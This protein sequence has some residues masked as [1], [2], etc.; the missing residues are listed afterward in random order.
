MIYKNNHPQNYEWYSF[1]YYFI[2]NFDDNRYEL[3]IL[4]WFRDNYVSEED[5]KHYYKI[6]PIIVEAIEEEEYKD[7]IY[8]YVYDNVIYVCVEAIK[9]G[10]YAFDYNRYKESILNLE[11][12]YLKPTIQQRLVRTLKR[13][14]DNSIM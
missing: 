5:I 7:I 8:N 14:I 1:I 13:Q 3:T 11:Q 10:D 12:T 9:N 2:I 4:R 6:A